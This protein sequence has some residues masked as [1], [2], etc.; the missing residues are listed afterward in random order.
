METRREFLKT[1]VVGTAALAVSRWGIDSVEAG[2]L[3]WTP[4]DEWLIIGKLQDLPDNAH[5]VI[6]EAVTAG[7]GKKRS[8]LKLIANRSGDQVFVMSTKCT[9]FSCE[10]N[11][12]KDGSFLCPCHGAQ[13]DAS[14]M[15]TKGPAKKPLPWYEVRIENGDVMVNM[16]KTTSALSK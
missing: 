2:I 9:H 16:T 5:T 11:Q 6:H 4:K 13:F 1:L 10:V 12:Q 15:V 14:G 3:P 7:K 8:G